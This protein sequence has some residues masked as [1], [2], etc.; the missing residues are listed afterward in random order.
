MSSALPRMAMSW[1]AFHVMVENVKN[2]K[3]L[4]SLPRFIV[5]M[6]VQGYGGVIYECTHN[7]MGTTTHPFLRMRRGQKHIKEPNIEMGGEES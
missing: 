3:F 7:T 1:Y 4:Y 6:K 5:Y 2:W